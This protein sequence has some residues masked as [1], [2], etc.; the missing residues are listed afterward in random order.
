[1]SYSWTKI[2]P[3]QARQH[4]L[5]GVGGWLL[6]FAIGS[7]LG[8]LKSFG[9]LAGEAAKAGMSIGQL[10]D[11]DHPA[12]TFAKTSLWLEGIALAILY[13]ALFSKQSSF[14]VIA[15]VIAA[16]LFP[17][18][19]VIGFSNQFEGLGEAV[20][21]G[22]FQWVF[23][24]AIWLSYLHRSRRVRVTFEHCIRSDE[25]PV[26]SQT[27]APTQ[28]VRIA[29]NPTPAINLTHAPITAPSNSLSQDSVYHPTANPQQ[30][31]MPTQNTSMPGNAPQTPAFDEDA[32]YEV[33]ANEMESGKLDKGLWT[34][35][36]VEMDGD[37]KRTKIA[38][39]KQR[40][41]KLMATE[42]E[43]VMVANFQAKQ[44]RLQQ[45]DAERKATVSQELAHKS[46]EKTGFDKFPL[47]ADLNL[48][49]RKPG[50]SSAR[51]LLGMLYIEGRVV[52]K[53]LIEAK[54]LVADAAALGDDL[55]KEVIQNFDDVVRYGFIY[56]SDNLWHYANY[57]YEK[58]GD[59]ISCARRSSST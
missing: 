59:A 33:V 18:E 7:A 46:S 31:V 55:A 58:L 20:A 26:N 14:R 50:Y 28:E 35:L 5:Y 13:W 1:M 36:F 57:R 49:S 56:G 6:V 16:G 30:P 42:H 44:L 54:T 53:D 10:L 40:A 3:D 12:M 32:V 21:I 22:M 51:F 38:Y 27:T 9:M 8:F 24:C 23:S 45:A 34:R 25:M 4:K 43:R 15:T 11:I 47:L 48:Y 29:L 39:I 19:A 17:L 2:S 37:E 41:E 52:T